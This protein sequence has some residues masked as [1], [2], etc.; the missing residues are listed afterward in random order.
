LADHQQKAVERVAR[1]YLSREVEMTFDSW[2]SQLPA[3]SEVRLKIRR[4]LEAEM[5]GGLPTGM[6]PL[7]RD[8]ALTFWH[9]WGIVTAKK[10]PA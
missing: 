10:L 7:E 2:Q 8:G 4:S 3:D 9:T 5:S 1:E 6:R